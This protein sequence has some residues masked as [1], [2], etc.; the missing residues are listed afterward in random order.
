MRKRMMWI[1]ASVVVVAGAGLW[2]SQVSHVEE[3]KYAVVESRGAIEIRDYPALIA[4]EATVTGDRSAA[5]NQ[6]FRLIADYIFGNNTTSK[7]VAMTAPVTQ[8]ASEKI[9]MTAPVT[10]QGAGNE[11]TVRFIMPAGYTMETLPTP[12]KTEVKLV[13]LPA[14]RQT[15]IRFS[16]VADEVLL[17]RKTDELNAFVASKNLQP[18]GAPTYAFYNPPWTLGPLRRNE[19]MVEVAK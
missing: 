6:G 4:A 1:I 13:T 8:Q 14:K 17:A 18:L 12:A 10:Q 5:I 2:W 19:V 16:G 15:V 11:W 9:A 7:K 3:P